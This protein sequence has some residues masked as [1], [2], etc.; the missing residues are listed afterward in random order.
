MYIK[1]W[2]D[3]IREAYNAKMHPDVFGKWLTGRWI[4]ITFSAKIK[5]EYKTID[6]LKK[7]EANVDPEKTG[8]PEFKM[9]VTGTPFAYRRGDGVIVCPIGC[10]KP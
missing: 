7:L 3:D 2:L 1:I 6:D 5:D 8:K 4:Q 10:L 9:V